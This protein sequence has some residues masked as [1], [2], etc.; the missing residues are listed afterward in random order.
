MSSVNPIKF[1]NRGPEYLRTAF[2][3][4]KGQKPQLSAAERLNIQRKSKSEQVSDI[5]YKLFV[6]FDLTCIIEF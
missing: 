4:N 6:N 2:Q 1:L 5:P 3:P